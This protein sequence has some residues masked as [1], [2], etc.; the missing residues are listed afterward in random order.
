VTA[1]TLIAHAPGLSNAG[2]AAPPRAEFT[3]P[4]T[5]FTFEFTPEKTREPLPIRGEKWLI[6]AE[7]RASVVWYPEIAGNKKGKWR[8]GMA[9][10]CAPSPPRP[11][12]LFRTT[13]RPR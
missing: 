1:L 6:G 9:P 8:A 11:A 5:G 10:Q 3:G 2:P 4:F 13:W 12:R 7:S